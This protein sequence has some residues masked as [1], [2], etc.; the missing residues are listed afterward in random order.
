MSG[1]IEVLLRSKDSDGEL[2]VTSLVLQRRSGGPPLHVHPLH[3]EGFYVLEGEVTA[4]IGEQ[5]TVVGPGSLAFAAK[6]VPHT[7]A[8]RGDTEA[9]M[10]VICAPAG[11]ESY[12]ER[13]AVDRD[14]RPDPA[15]AVAV[16]PGI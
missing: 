14:A 6:G 10:L 4:R 5:L 12:F 13:L 3:G 9:R 7:F 16:G 11:F 8:N 2:S 15:D 1:P